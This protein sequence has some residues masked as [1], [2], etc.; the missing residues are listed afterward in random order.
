MENV[1][2]LKQ[3]IR[4]VNPKIMEDAVNVIKDFILIWKKKYAKS[5]IS[6]V[7]H[8]TFK[9]ELVLIVIRAIALIPVTEIVKFLS[10]IPIA[11][12]LTKI[13]LV[14]FVQVNILLVLTENVHQRTLS[15]RTL[16]RVMDCVLHASQDMD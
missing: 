11:K 12:I 2:L 9:Q 8:Q 7:N 15:V 10:K 16:I 1:L 14:K 3:L 13:I 4:T 6:Y 5:L